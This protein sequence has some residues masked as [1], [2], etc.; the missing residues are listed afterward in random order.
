MEGVPL[1]RLIFDYPTE[2]A[3][4][5]DLFL[6]LDQ[7]LGSGAFVRYRVDTP[8]GALAPAYYE[9]VTIGVLNCLSEVRKTSGDQV[10]QKII[11]AKQ[12]ARFRDNT[13]PGANSKEKQQNRIDTIREALLA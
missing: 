10:R 1:G 11:D 7:T 2:E 5:K 4:F 13:G 8:V 6:Y 12:S 3:T 9:A